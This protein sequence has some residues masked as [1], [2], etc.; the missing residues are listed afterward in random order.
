MK[1]RLNSMVHLKTISATSQS[2]HP[3][4]SLIGFLLSAFIHGLKA[5]GASLMVIS[6]ADP[7]PSQNTALAAV[8]ESHK[9][10]ALRPRLKSAD[11]TFSL[12]RP[13]LPK[14]AWRNA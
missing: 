11:A 13:T 14:P 1:G 8:P 7:I 3:R 2:A 5:Y 9:H 4:S 12:P 6:P 10:V